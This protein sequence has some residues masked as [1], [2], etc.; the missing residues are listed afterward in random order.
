MWQKYIYF[1]SVDLPGNDFLIFY[2]SKSWESIENAYKKMKYNF[3][4][5]K[6]HIFIDS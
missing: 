1:H 6:V 5:C 3:H 4:I 2:L